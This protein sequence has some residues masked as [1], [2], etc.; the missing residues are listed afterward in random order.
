MT[1]VYTRRKRLFLFI[2]FLPFILNIFWSGTGPGWLY[3]SAR[4]I[5]HFEEIL[6]GLIL[7]FFPLA[8]QKYFGAQADRRIAIFLIILGIYFFVIGFDGFS[9]LTHRWLTEC[10]NTIECLK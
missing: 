3:W 6:A 2:I 9:G 5:G 10:N 7:V 8:L 1:T 4:F